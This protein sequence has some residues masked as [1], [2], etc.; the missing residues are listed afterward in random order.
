MRLFLYIFLILASFS[1]AFADSEIGDLEKRLEN[2]DMDEKI[3]ILNRLAELYSSKDANR[4]I[5]YATRALELA[6]PQQ[7]RRQIARAFNTI[8]LAHIHAG[9]TQYSIEFFKKALQLNKYLEDYLELAKT[10]NNI[11]M[12][13]RYTSN[14]HAALN[15]HLEAL[16]YSQ[17]ASAIEQIVAS[18]N[19]AGIIFRNINMNEKALDFYTTALN[20][21]QNHNYR[22][23]IALS[24]NNLGSF[25]WYIDQNEKA[26]N[27]YELAKK[28][29]WEIDSV[30][31]GV[32]GSY[33]NIANVYRTLGEYDK[34]LELY[35]KSLNMSTDNSDRN[36]MAVTMK[37]IGICYKL[38]KEYVSA[39]DF[40]RNALGEATKASLNKYILDTYYELSD[41]YSILGNSDKALEYYKLYSVRKDSLF[42]QYTTSV[43][44]ELSFK[45]DIDTKKKQIEEL[46]ADNKSSETT[47]NYMIV[48]V[49]LVFVLTGVLLS[50][51]RASKKANDKLTKQNETISKQKDELDMLLLDLK[52][53]EE[54]LK[55]ANNS[56]DK[57]FSVIGHDLKNPMQVILSSSSLALEHFKHENWEKSKN[58]LHK[59]TKNTH[60]SLELLNNLLTWA[61]SQSQG[62]SVV[63]NEVS[64]E[65]VVTPLYDMIEE[66]RNRK[67]INVTL[68]VDQSA[69]VFADV[70]MLSTVLRNLLNN[71]MKFTNRKGNIT[72]TAYNE[73][74]NA[75]IKIKDD[76][77]G[78]NESMKDRLFDL[79]RSQT[80]P[81]TED[82]KGTGLGLILCKEFIDKNHG[83]IL[84]ESKLNFGTEF[85]IILP[86][87]DNSDL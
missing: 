9:K 2:S 84:V 75:Y 79:G 49:V 41:L 1:L 22:K 48:I 85:T 57:L 42:N 47:R 63:P 13:H 29:Y 37:N 50:K 33:N 40:L 38:K 82:E 11:G 31:D 3:I 19:N 73:D 87:K 8:G 24:Y 54:A 51:N 23:G 36:L 16:G 86:A 60:I 32:A 25:Y 77:V 15:Y 28:E 52:K 43:V 12:A 58:H 56:K 74:H 46:I 7:N 39:L 21:S 14:Y 45:Y 44:A 20:L 70:N 10:Y 34:A 83:Q 66:M 71:A 61:R 69:K 59:I 64:I 67:E 26:L 18:Y 55:V 81:G 6:K 27:Y 80:M 62:I 53:S 68:N 76:G 35:K 65:S 17:R 30:G 78:M 5:D 4:S 72:L